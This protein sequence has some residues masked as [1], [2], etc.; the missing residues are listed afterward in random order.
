[1]KQAG[2]VPVSQVPMRSK[3]RYDNVHGPQMAMHPPH[4]RPPECPWLLAAETDGTRCKGAAD[5]E[6]SRPNVHATRKLTN[7]S[8]G[9][10]EAPEMEAHLY[11]NNPRVPDKVDGHHNGAENWEHSNS[12]V[13]TKSIR[14]NS[15]VSKRT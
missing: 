9:G 14:V 3:T 4:S 15:P 8:V 6:C 12:N 7:L 13:E 1:M 11:G 5:H 2:N 10:Q